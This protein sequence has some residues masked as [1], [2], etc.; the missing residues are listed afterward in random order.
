M[1][2]VAAEDAR[3]KFLGPLGL[4][5]D[6]LLGARRGPAGL[7]VDEGVPGSLSAQGSFALEVREP[8]AA[9]EAMHDGNGQQL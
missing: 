3:L 4:V 1:V 6:G 2:D 9:V 7:Q 8:V 5:L